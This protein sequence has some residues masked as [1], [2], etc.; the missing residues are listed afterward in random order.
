MFNGVTYFGEIASNPYQFVK[1]VIQST[2]G[3]MCQAF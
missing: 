2:L 1:Q 3:A